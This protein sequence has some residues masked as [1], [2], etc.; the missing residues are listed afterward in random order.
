MAAKI[1]IDDLFFTQL[2]RQHAGKIFYYFKKYVKQDDIAEDLLQ[3]LFANLWVKRELI[4]EDK[5]P[6]GY[7]FVSARN[8][9]YNHLAKSLR[10]GKVIALQE[11]PAAV[12]GQQP[13]DHIYYNAIY[14]EY[15]SV[16]DFMSPQRKKAFELSRE[17]GLSYKE[18]AASMGISTKTVESHITAVLQVLRRKIGHLLLLFLIFFLF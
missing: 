5:N 16:L 14:Q 9:L 7:L 10:A 6:E 3:E 18:I 4:Q 13:E 11:A 8:Q 1:P 12:T 15:R 17:Y 2:F